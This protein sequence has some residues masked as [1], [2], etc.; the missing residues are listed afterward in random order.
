M[1]ELIVIAAV[2][3]AGGGWIF[4]MY[5]G[6][7]ATRNNVQNAFHNIDVVLQ[8]RNEELSKLVD[9]CTAYMKHESGLLER[10]VQLRTG[11]AQAK[12]IDRKDT[13]A[14]EISALLQQLK[15]VWEQ[16]PDLKA[17]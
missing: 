10:L 1:I 15:M 14:N 9:A 11:Y 16:Y 2:L 7:V 8:Q 13:A 4:S 12:E 17:V 6:I 5:N 3:L